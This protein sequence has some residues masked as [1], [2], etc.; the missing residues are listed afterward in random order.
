VRLHELALTWTAAVQAA[1][2]AREVLVLE[3]ARTCVS[4]VEAQAKWLTTRLKTGAPQ[5]LT[6]P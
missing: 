6:I 4:E 2:A 1:Q 5:A 3:L